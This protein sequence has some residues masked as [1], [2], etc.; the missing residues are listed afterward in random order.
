MAMLDN[1][2]ILVGQDTFR[3][4]QPIGE[5][6]RLAHAGLK[7]LI[8]DDDLVAGLGLIKRLGGGGVL[9][10]VDGVFQRGARPCPTLL[11]EDQHDE[12]TEVGGL[13]REELNLKTFGQ[14][15]QLLLLLGGATHALH[16]VIARVTFHGCSL[17]GLGLL[18]GRLY[19]VPSQRARRRWKFLNGDILGL[20]LGH[21]AGVD[22]D[23][24]LAVG[25]DI[26]FG[27]EVIESRHAIDPAAD[28][29][30]FGEDAVFVPF[31]FLDRS[32]H[33]GGVLRLSDDLIAAALVVDLA[34][35]ALAVVHLVAAHLR[36]IRHAHAAH[37][38]T[39]IDETRSGQAQFDAQIKVLV[40]LLGREEEVLG[41]L[42]RERTAAD[43]A[44][45]DAP[46]SG[47][48]L[49]A[50][51][52]LPIKQGNWGGVNGQGEEQGQEATHGKVGL[53]KS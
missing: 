52:G 45:L 13:L 49:P 11:V 46:P 10:G 16:I 32:E 41:D 5:G 38:N 17:G 2:A 25:G 47:I 39:A 21:A 7:G 30:P 28:A 34:V 51:K 40:R 18:F 44:S 3:N 36:A 33:G 43:L 31:A 19:L 9:V 27:L 20:N 53:I 35:P 4:R 23:A 42:R 29:I 1:R 24:D 50:S 26:R 22:L 48:T 37:L 12:L 8:E 15:E 6:A 14:L